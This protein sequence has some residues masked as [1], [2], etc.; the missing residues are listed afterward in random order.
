M[1]YSSFDKLMGNIS[2][3]IVFITSATAEQLFDKLY[4]AIIVL[5]MFVCL[6]ILYIFYYANIRFRFVDSFTVS[7]C[8]KDSTH[9]QQLLITLPPNLSPFAKP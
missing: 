8:K 5:D 6:Y 2:C 1:L 7:C 9:I 3:F 4:R